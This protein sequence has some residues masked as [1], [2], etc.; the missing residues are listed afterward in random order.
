MQVLEPRGEKRA[1]GG[2]DYELEEAEEAL[3]G[4]WTGGPGKNKRSK[5]RHAKFLVEKANRSAASG[6]EEPAELPDAAAA[7][8]AVPS[9]AS[10]AQ[11]RAREQ[12]EGAL[13]RAVGTAR[14]KEWNTL[15]LPT[16]R[17]GAFHGSFVE[18]LGT[19]HGLN[20]L[21]SNPDAVNTM[22]RVPSL[23]CLQTLY[24]AIDAMTGGKL[25]ENANKSSYPGY[26]WFCASLKWG[27]GGDTADKITVEA[28]GNSVSDRAVQHQIDQWLGAHATF[29]QF[30]VNILAE[31][32]MAGR[33]VR[34]D[35]TALSDVAGHLLDG[36]QRGTEVFKDWVNQH[37]G[38]CHYKAAN[39]V[40]V[41]VS[42]RGA[43]ACHARLKRASHL[44]VLTNVTAFVEAILPATFGRCSEVTPALL[45]Y[46]GW[47][48]DEGSLLI[49][50]KGY[51]NIAPALDGRVEHIMAAINGVINEL[52]QT[53]QL[54]PEQAFA[55]GVIFSYRS[56]NENAFT[57]EDVIGRL[58]KTLSAPDMARIDLVY[59]VGV[60]RRR[61]RARVR[62]R[63]RARCIRHTLARPIGRDATHAMWPP[64][65]PRTRS[66]A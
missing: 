36:T 51:G 32:Q 27:Y 15:W 33:L 62:A 13:H 52:T 41:Q 23:E 39:T 54:T 53:K 1:R 24:F 49:T 61:G 9:P 64:R 6:V 5:A 35:H 38:Y 34:L 22:F 7:A 25:M 10:V 46:L 31:W 56:V 57:A 3:I 30:L 17:V 18:L 50:D 29:V 66:P 44:Q 12:R 19:P 47:L 8:A 28:L 63:S 42:F 11:T 58:Q 45:F 37:S 20:Y 65:L 59:A 21:A 40:N 48:L 14:L 60:T 55:A 2:I 4:D 43:A 16:E 26:I